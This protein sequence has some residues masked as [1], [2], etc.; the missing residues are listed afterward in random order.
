MAGN[1]SAAK[2]KHATPKRRA[3]AYEKRSTAEKPPEPAP[4]WR[5][6]GEAAE[7]FDTSRQAF[8]ESVRSL[9][10]PE[11]IKNSG[12]RGLLIH[13]RSAI[14][15]WVKRKI[16][17]F[18]PVFAGEDAGGESP[19]LERYRAARA[20]REEKKRDLEL[21]QLVALEEI[22]PEMLEFADVLK[23]AAQLIQ[24]QYGPEPAAILDSALGEA[25]QRW[26]TGQTTPP[27]NGQPDP[28]PQTPDTPA[29]RRTRTDHP[30]RPVR[31]PKI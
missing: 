8:H 16:E 31:R 29:I 10:P 12:D 2:K 15:A 28:R 7:I 19:H 14:D 3:S 26:R 25:L 18:T 5:T 24:R 13:L 6:L 23:G 11:A 4:G 20:D 9:L 1:S 22:R 30:H 21:G 17:L 27:G